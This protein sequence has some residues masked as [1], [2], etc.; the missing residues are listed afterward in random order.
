MRRF[1]AIFSVIF[2]VFL[3][4]A[5]LPGQQPSPAAPTATPG[6]AQPTPAGRGGRG[7]APAVRSPEVLTD[8]RV[9]FR[10]RA[11]NAKEVGV[12]VAGS[13]LP[14]QKD[15]QGVWS[16]TSNVLAPNYYT[17]SILVDGTSIND[18]NNRQAQTSF[19][20]FQSMFVVPG[21][22]PWFPAQNV[23][24]GALTR[25]RFHSAIANDER[26][27]FV[28]TPPGYDPRRGKAY[29]LLYLLHG[30][31]DDAE[32]WMNGG[33]ANVILDN[34]IAQGKAVPMVVVATLGY[35]TSAGPNAP[36]ADI[37]TGYDKILLNEV[38][39]LVQKGYHV[40]A[41]REERAI[42]GLSMG[43]AETLYTGLNNLDKF[44]WLGSFSGAFVMWPRGATASVPAAAA[45]ATTSPAS[46]A[47]PAD[48]RGGRGGRGG[49]APLDD[50]VFERNFPNLNAKANSR[51][52]HLFIACGTADGLIGVNRQF[53]TWLKS[54][55]V[56]FTEEEAPDMGHV[57]PL[58]RKNFADFAQKVFK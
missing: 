42:A 49:G 48:G 58:W 44:A 38:M 23:A 22:E 52:K 19:G 40:S 31:G 55:G 2:G 4:A 41:N 54:K 36:S 11:P 47:A 39:P 18:P 34:L 27:Y 24:R 14:M 30:L 50:S 3:A 20:G 53:K 25:H 15:E 7:G 8:G 5:T 33:A 43:G 21:P 10:L 16:A 26:D 1:V 13:T 6:T 12:S 45:A 46:S 28:Y 9:T 56:Q 37:V 29:P 51:I 32:R 57:W 35:G 17:Y